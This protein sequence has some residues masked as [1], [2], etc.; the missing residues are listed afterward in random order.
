MECVPV[1]GQYKRLLIGKSYSS[2]RWL[3]FFLFFA[4][5]III[6][7]LASD[8]IGATQT[9][10]TPPPSKKS[11]FRSTLADPLNNEAS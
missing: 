1:S 8:S 5:S 9:P 6:L 2:I 11:E 10:K 4:K 3:L 7:F